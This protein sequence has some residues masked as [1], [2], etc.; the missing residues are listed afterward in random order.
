MTGGKDYNGPVLFGKQIFANAGANFIVTTGSGTPFSKQS[1]IT[2]EAASGIN[3]RSVLEGSINGSR[4]PWS[5]R[6]SSRFSKR[7]AI[8]WDTKEGA[9]KQANVNVY[10]QV[11]NLLNNQNVIS[12]YRATGKP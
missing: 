3:D 6:V 2:Q 4:L 1:N 10:L 12:V 5:F 9:K 7:F 8:K 11:Q